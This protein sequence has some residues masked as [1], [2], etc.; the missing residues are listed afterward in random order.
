[1]SMLSLENLIIVH[2]NRERYFFFEKIRI[3]RKKNSKTGVASAS[4][5]WYNR[6]YKE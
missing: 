2:L 6:A 5:L 4:A 3:M 1:M